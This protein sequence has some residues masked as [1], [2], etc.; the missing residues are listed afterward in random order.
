[1]ISEMSVN[2]WCNDNG[3]G[4]DDRVKEPHPVV[5]RLGPRFLPWQL[6]KSVEELW[7]ECECHAENFW[8]LL[9]D[10]QVDR[11]AKSEDGQAFHQS[12]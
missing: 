9:E 8:L 4:Y 5:Q 6:E 2:V 10:S 3:L 12:C 7:L 11:E 1:M